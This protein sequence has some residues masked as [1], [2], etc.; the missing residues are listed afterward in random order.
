MNYSGNSTGGMDN[1]TI[2]PDQDNGAPIGQWTIEAWE[3]GT[4]T[5]GE[6]LRRLCSDL[7]E[8]ERRHASQLGQ[9]GT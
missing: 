2:D 9:Q 6:A 1:G 4:L 5:D 7:G 3:D 8:D